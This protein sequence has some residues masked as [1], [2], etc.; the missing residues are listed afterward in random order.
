MKSWREVPYP[1]ADVRTAPACSI[2]S[3]NISLYNTECVLTG[4]WGSCERVGGPWGA[5]I[6]VTG[7][8]AASWGPR[9]TRTRSAV[10]LGLPPC[11][12]SKILNEFTDLL[13]IS[14][15]FA[16]GPPRLCHAF[17]L[18][19]CNCTKSIIAYKHFP[20]GF[21]LSPRTK[22]IYWL[23]R[24]CQWAHAGEIWQI[25]LGSIGLCWR[26]VLC[27]PL[28]CLSNLL[29]RTQTKLFVKLCKYQ[30]C[31]ICLVCQGQWFL[32]APFPFSV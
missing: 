5:L 22:G 31:L 29:L 2:P 27:K 16:K 25:A 4:L 28:I 26:R 30:V 10:T 23:A 15:R 6:G 17:F 13:C 21:R 20:E 19:S 14:G 11:I 24:A 9:G 18:G 3:N 7:W 1:R 8:G 32:A 12:F